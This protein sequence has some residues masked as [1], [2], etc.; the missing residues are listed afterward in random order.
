[1]NAAVEAVG[2]NLNG[3]TS[4]DVSYYYTPTH[5]S[6]VG[7]ALE[8][9]GDMLTRPLLTHLELEKEIVLE[10][11]LDEVDEKGRDIDVDNLVKRELYAPHP[12]GLKIAGTPES[13]RKLTARQV[14]EHFR[15]H[16]VTG[17]VIVGVAGPVSRRSVLRQTA[18]AFR[19]M[20]R[21]GQVTEA[22]PPPAKLTGPRLKFVSLDESQV[23]FRLVFPAVSEEHPDY[24]ALGMLRRVLDD[25]LSSR[26]PYN[27]VERRGLAYAVGA[28]I[29]G[30]HDTGTFEIDGAC[31]SEKVGDTVDEIC[32]T[33][34]TLV[35]GRISDEE[36]ARAKRRHRMH[37][38]F[39]RDAPGDLIGWFAGTAIFREPEAFA[40]RAR[41]VDAL[42]LAELKAVA[43]RYFRRENLLCVAVG[44]RDGKAR[45]ER[46]VKRAKGL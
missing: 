26:L 6:S 5:P 3:V 45:L 19:A 42:T 9:L 7:V 10:E 44:P 17:N 39:T 36:L 1:M 22:P 34:G 8:I 27:V 13:V 25:G 33:L 40:Q 24:L 18:A 37:L 43:R 38:D 21:G 16:Y 12:L 32:R 46:A 23:S 31:A 35:R 29:E 11:M 20:P 14:K 41:R 15:A 2:G 28:L 30:F 4:R